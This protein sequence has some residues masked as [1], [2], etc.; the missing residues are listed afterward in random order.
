MFP[1]E[2]EVVVDRRNDFLEYKGHFGGDSNV[3]YLYCGST[4]T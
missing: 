3:Q 1:G 2:K 4:Y